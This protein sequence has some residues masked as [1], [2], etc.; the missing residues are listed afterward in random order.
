MR[1]LLIQI[2]AYLGLFCLP[3]LLIFGLS[4]LDFNHEFDL[5]QAKIGAMKQMEHKV[6]LVD[7]LDKRAMAQAINDSLDIMGWY[8]PWTS[9][10]DSVQFTYTTSHFGKEYHMDVSLPDERVRISTSKGTISHLLKGL[11][12]L[13]EE[14]PNAPWWI[15]SWQYYQDLSVYALLFW[16]ITG[17]ILWSQKNQDR[18]WG[19]FVLLTLL[20]FSLSLMLYIWAVG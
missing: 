13:G 2:H 6:S 8:I 7:S 4:S 5:L 17:I 16:V 3:Y 14:I 20:A 10:K 18:N 1:K 11:H 9:H 12:G 19:I 15:N